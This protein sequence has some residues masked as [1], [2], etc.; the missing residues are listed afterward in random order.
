[1]LTALVDETMKRSAICWLEYEGS[2]WSRG[3]WHVWH[4]GAAYVVSGGEEQL[5]PGID[6]ATR[7]VVTARAKDSRERVVAWVAKA[8]TLDPGTEEW[9]AA[10]DALRPHRLNAAGADDLAA[11]WAEHSTITKL[12]PTGEVS[13]HPGAYPAGSL[14]AAPVSSPAT[15]TGRPPA[16]IHRRQRRAPDL[17]GT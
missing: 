11:R 2:G 15:T 4:D 17:H 10:A 5:L 8:A 9:R 1:M 3:V 6:R 12:E 14:A 13:E 7:V 16:V